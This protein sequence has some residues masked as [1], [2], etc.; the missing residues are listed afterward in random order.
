MVII[1]KF[2]LWFGKT[3]S[4]IIDDKLYVEYIKINV[5]HIMSNNIVINLIIFFF[6]SI[7]SISFLFL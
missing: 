4:L 2:I 5:V 1:I 7:F 6:I 3:M